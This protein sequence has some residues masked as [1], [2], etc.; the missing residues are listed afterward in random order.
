LDQAF[1]FCEGYGEPE[2]GSLKSRVCRGRQE[3][4]SPSNFARRQI[5]KSCL[6]FERPIRQ[7]RQLETTRK[8]NR[9]TTKENVDRFS[10]V[11]LFSLSYFAVAVFTFL[12]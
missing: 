2:H 5:L 3:R 7:R 12:A 10:R 4:C 1:S 9:M 8:G 6:S 11:A